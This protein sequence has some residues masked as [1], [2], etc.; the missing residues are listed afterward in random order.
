MEDI[1]IYIMHIIIIIIASVV[2]LEQ[3]VCFPLRCFKNV[4]IGILA[5]LHLSLKKTERKV[6]VGKNVKT[7]KWCVAL[8][9]MSTS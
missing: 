8:N 5:A 6:S 9:L 2:L 4:L 7:L 1:R 3:Y